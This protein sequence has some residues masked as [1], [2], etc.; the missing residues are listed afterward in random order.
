[1]FRHTTVEATL[2]CTGASLLLLNLWVR[3]GEI[4]LTEELRFLRS[5]S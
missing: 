2:N 3:G 4:G 5:V 1:M